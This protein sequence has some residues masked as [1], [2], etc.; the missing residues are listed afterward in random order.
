[1]NA[2]KYIKD[3]E[4]AGF[5]RQQAEAQVQMVLDAVEANL[6]TKHDLA[7]FQERSEGRFVQ[8]GKD[9]DGRFLQ[10]SQRMESR[11]EQFSQHMESRFEQFSQHME[12]RF[13]QFSRHMESRFEQFKQQVQSQIR[14]SEL[15]MTIR[16]GLM[17]VSTMTLTIAI[18]AWIAK[19]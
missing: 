15:R 8:F 11:F 1:M 14:E 5:E 9:M 18:L 7:I 4:A 16:L 13:E 6:A 10:F 2:M 3:L 17:M 12:S 19:A